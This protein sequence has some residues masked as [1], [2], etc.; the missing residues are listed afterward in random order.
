MIGNVLQH[1]ISLSPV[2]LFWGEMPI[3]ALSW[4]LTYPI[5]PCSG[6]L[7]RKIFD[8]A[9]FFHAIIGPIWLC[10]PSCGKRQREIYSLAGKWN[11]F[12]FTKVRILSDVILSQLWLEVDVLLSELSLH[13]F[14]RQHRSAYVALEHEHKDGDGVWNSLC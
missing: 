2:F 1:I 9:S 14:V 7:W 5:T 3:A 4:W 11:F 12:F 8:S 10:V 6:F 13:S